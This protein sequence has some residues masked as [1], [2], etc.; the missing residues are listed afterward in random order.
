MKKEYVGEGR[1]QKNPSVVGGGLIG[2]GTPFFCGTDILPR[3][4][5]EVAPKVTERACQILKEK[6][7]KIPEIS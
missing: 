4:L 2:K 3:P 6:Y 7:K 1:F 5:G